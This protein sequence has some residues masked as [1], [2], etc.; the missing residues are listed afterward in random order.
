MIEKYTT[1]MI[2]RSKIYADDRFNCRGEITVTS[3]AELARDIQTRGLDY[4]VTVQ[5]ASDV[6]GGLPAGFEYRI[7]AGHRRF[8]ATR[9]IGWQQVPCMIKSGMDEVEARITNLGEN[10]NERNSTSCRKRER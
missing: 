2:D 7:I 4:P 3:V 10:S 8:I 9:V 5:P 6:K 1:Q